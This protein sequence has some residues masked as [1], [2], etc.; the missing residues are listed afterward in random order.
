MK[1]VLL[2]DCLG[3]LGE[4]MLCAA[5]TAGSPRIPNPAPR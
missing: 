3:A 1:G 2:L 5:R 4:E